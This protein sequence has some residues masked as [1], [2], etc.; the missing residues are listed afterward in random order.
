MKKYIVRM[1]VEA[2]DMHGAAKA[3]LSIA[4]QPDAELR[5]EDSG[6][7]GPWGSIERHRVADLL[8]ETHEQ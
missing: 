5:V 3:A 8:K 6:Y 1:E 4:N 2:E 7:T